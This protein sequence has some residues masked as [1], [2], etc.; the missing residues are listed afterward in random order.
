MSSN[1]KGRKGVG[2]LNSLPYHMVLG[3][4]TDCRGMSGS[5]LSRTCAMPKDRMNMELPSAPC[6]AQSVT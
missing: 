3:V 2:S 6:H 4:G 1:A 5:S